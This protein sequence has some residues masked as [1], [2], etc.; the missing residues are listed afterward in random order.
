MRWFERVDDQLMEVEALAE[1][2]EVRCAAQ[3]DLGV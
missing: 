2:P 1:H 3:I